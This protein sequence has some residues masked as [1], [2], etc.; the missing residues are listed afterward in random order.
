MQRVSLS[1]DYSSYYTDETSDS[2]RTGDESK[3]KEDSE[4]A[5]QASAPEAAPPAAAP[6]EAAPPEAAPE[7][8]QQEKKSEA[9]E[10]AVKTQHAAALASS[11]GVRCKICDKWLKNGDS[12]L[13]AH[14]ETSV[15][16][17][18]RQGS[19]GLRKQCQRCFKWI[20]DNDW[21]WQQHSWH[22]Q[23]SEDDKGLKNRSKSPEENLHR[24]RFELHSRPRGRSRSPLKLPRHHG[25][26]SRDRYGDGSGRHDKADGREKPR[27][28][29]RSRSRREARPSCPP[30]A[31]PAPPAPADSARRRHHKEEKLE[32]ERQQQQARG[33]VRRV[34]S[35]SPGRVHRSGHQP[36]TRKSRTMVDS[37][38]FPF[39]YPEGRGGVRV[40]SDQRRQGQ[41]QHDQPVDQAPPQPPPESPRLPTQQTQQMQ[42]Q[43]QP[44]QIPAPPVPTWPKQIPMPP[45]LQLQQQ[46]FEGRRD[47]LR[48]LF[49]GVAGLLQGDQESGT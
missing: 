48:A 44:K 7:R 25:Q 22:C 34:A 14:L 49:L 9:S 11:Q 13:R 12:A 18:T 33:H 45:P 15:R 6:P 4:L 20:A 43:A 42:M 26:S 35:P 17:Q 46:Q 10:T 32:Q 21:S 23:G 3:P 37:G 28:C 5:A 27:N 30:P 39:G 38:D 8:E 41:S 2:S 31:P 29:A 16:C 47:S 40:Q 36:A 24:P 19:T 1:P